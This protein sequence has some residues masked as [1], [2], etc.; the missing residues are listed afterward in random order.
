MNM[1]TDAKKICICIAGV[2]VAIIS[3]ILSQ[4]I[5]SLYFLWIVSIPIGI[6]ILLTGIKIKNNRL[7]RMWIIVF[8]IFITFSFGIMFYVA[9]IVDD[10][11]LGNDNKK[12][13]V[14][15][16][17]K[18]TTALRNG[19]INRILK[20][21]DGK[22]RIIFFGKTNCNACDDFRPHL[23]NVCKKIS[24]TVYYYNTEEMLRKE[25][26]QIVKKLNLGLSNICD[27][28]AI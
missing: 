17:P 8:G 16:P 2:F 23:E 27:K 12:I 3:W 14:I 11:K 5:K 6:F 28:K 20:E 25:A 1:K 4:N 19:E 21:K 15:S 7:L 26:L 22:E 10:I 24:V 18:G 13:I 9:G